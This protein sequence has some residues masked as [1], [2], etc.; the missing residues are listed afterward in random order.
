MVVYY[1]DTSAILKR[2]RTEKGT[3]V[4]E[5][6][7]GLADV[8]LVTSHFGCLEVEGVAARALKGKILTEEAYDALLNGF[9][10]DLGEALYVMPVTSRIVN[11]SIESARKYALK[12]ADSIHIASGL[13]VQSVGDDGDDFVFVSSDHGQLE[14][15]EAAGM[16]TLDPE[17][18][19]AMEMLR[20]T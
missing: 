4:V 16:Q 2:Y 7:Y 19:G 20:K 6:I 12:G 11:E 18:E 1:L 5:A 9:A 14:G 17:A 13:A 8:F 15:A 3:D 10:A